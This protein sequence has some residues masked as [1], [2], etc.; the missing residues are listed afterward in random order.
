MFVFVMGG[1]GFVSVIGRLYGI[2][3][4]NGDSLGPCEVAVARANIFDALGEEEKTKWGVFFWGDL[5]GGKLFFFFF[6]KPGVAACFF[7]I[8]DLKRPPPPPSFPSSS[9]FFFSF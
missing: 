6:E 2:E 7:L 4:L 5:G 8:D 3:S 9:F 1:K